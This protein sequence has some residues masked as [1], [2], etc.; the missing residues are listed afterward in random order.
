MI[1]YHKLFLLVP[2]KV[3]SQ[4]QNL[5]IQSP[6]ISKLVQ[7]YP[8]LPRLGNHLVTSLDHEFGNALEICFDHQLVVL[9]EF[10]LNA[11]FHVFEV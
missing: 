6:Q 10:L 8:D 9:N 5:S 7:I 3:Q 2:T 1:H 4:I 11:Q